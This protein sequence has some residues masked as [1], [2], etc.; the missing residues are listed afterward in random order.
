MPS[1]L[2]RVP[3]L[4]YRAAVS[5][6]EHRAP[7]M[8]AS[9]AFYTLFSLGPVL[10]IAVT[11]AGYVYGPAAAQ[12]DLLAEVARVLGPNAALAVEAIVQGA[13]NR[14]HGLWSTVVALVTGFVGAT[15]VF[16]ELK[17]SLDLIW[18]TPPDPGAGLADLLK[19]RLLSFGL[20]VGIGFVLL[21]S[22]LFSALID[23]AQQ[24]YGQFM[25]L[26]V[27][28]LAWLGNLVTLA[29]VTVL[30]A[31]IYKLLP[32]KKID[33]R[34]VWRSA[35]LTALLFLAGKSVIAYYL[36]RVAVA[37]SYGAVG[38][39]VVLLLWVYYSAQVFLYG[40]ALSREIR[41]ARVPSR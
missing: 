31:A 39:L 13:A 40:A 35:L 14:Q 29:V 32:Q 25:G 34:D 6:L 9:L 1:L 2:L 15:T 18:D 17:S 11:I 27:S 10:L 23:A 24:H 5:W 20:V 3:L 30:F 22:M 38:T 26:P 36:G 37:S 7:T 33:W 8:G 41:A 19:S 21:V 16:V 28:L 12:A 4:L